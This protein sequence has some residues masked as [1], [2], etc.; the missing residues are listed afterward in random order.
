MP[1]T[2]SITESEAK[3]LRDA[4]KHCKEVNAYRRLEAVALRGEGKDNAQIGPLTGY[5]P[6]WVSKL[7]SQFRNE[8]IHALLEDGR[9]GGNH[10]NLTKE[11]EENILKEFE[12]AARAGQLI[13][14]AEIKKRYDE[15]LNP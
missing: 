13:T 1:K 3:M 15:F 7:V 14:P 9:H 8:G 5:H 4:M 11:Q 10:Q 2:Y 12:E 6:D